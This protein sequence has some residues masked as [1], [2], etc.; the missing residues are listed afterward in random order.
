MGS[1]RRYPTH[2]TEEALPLRFS[3]RLTQ[4]EL[5]PMLP[6]PH[7]PCTPAETH[8]LWLSGNGLDR[9]VGTGQNIPNNNKHIRH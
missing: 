6:L 8:L 7:I 1:R 4:L 3:G 9:E 5:E 2:H